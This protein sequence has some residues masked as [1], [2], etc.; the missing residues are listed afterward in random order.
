MSNAQL[1]EEANIQNELL[2]TEEQISSGK[3]PDEEVFE[4]TFDG[5]TFGP[6]WQQDIKEFLT[7]ANQYTEETQVKS[8]SSDNW[9]SVFDHPLF[10]RRRP[11]LVS[12]HSLDNKETTFQIL[13]DG[14][15][16]GPYSLYEISAMVKT[17]EILLTDEVSIDEGT[18]WG[19]LYDI[20]EFDRRNLKSN[21]QLPSLP[22]DGV[23]AKNINTKVDEKTNLIAG[24]A[25]IGNLR[26]GKAKHATVRQEPQAQSDEE[27]SFEENVEGKKKAPLW[28]IL[29]LISIVGLSY[30]YTTWDS[31]TEKEEITTTKQNKKI[32]NKSYSNK[33]PIKLRPVKMRPKSNAKL[34][35]GSNVSSRPT[36]FKKSKAFRQAAKKQKK[37]L[38]N[39]ALINVENDDYY[40]DDN[41]DPVELDPI[42]STLSKETIDPELDGEF[43]DI[44]R[45]PASDEIFDE[46]AEF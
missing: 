36:S 38:T 28:P 35:T 1:K 15:V 18:S 26:T 41:T 45:A 27:F 40:Y 25:Y 8:L 3:F 43:D 20:E 13:K 10:Q 37:R 44:E 39:N 34:S 6:I 12:T 24:L 31:K 32:R 42:R 19:H 30:L 17:N 22:E 23:L 14:Q 2:L 33:A 9:V 16:V 46:E 4:I 5:Q 21:E 11:Q 7:H 29:F